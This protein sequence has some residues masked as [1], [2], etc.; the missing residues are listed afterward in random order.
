MASTFKGIQTETTE[1]PVGSTFK[2]I[3]TETTAVP[4]GTTFKGIQVEI[5]VPKGFAQIIKKKR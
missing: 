1:V 5:D 3:Q 4:I 2:G